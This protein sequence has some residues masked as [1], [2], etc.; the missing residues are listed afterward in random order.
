M[1]RVTGREAVHGLR[2]PCLH[3]QGAHCVNGAH[4]AQRALQVH[5]VARE[6]VEHCLTAQAVAAWHLERI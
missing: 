5:H 3:R 4:A 2:R 1:Q 6:L